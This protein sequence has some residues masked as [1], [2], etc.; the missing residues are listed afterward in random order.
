MTKAKTIMVVIQDFFFKLPHKCYKEVFK[1]RKLQL[2][3]CG[4]SWLLCANSCFI[5]NNR[6]WSEDLSVQLD[7]IQFKLW[8]LL[9]TKPSICTHIV[10]N[11]DHSGHDTSYIV[12]ANTEY[13]SIATTITKKWLENIDWYK[14]WFQFCL[15]HN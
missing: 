8:S 15:L 4:H 13:T 2:T 9:T 14:D 3:Y 1:I 12:P 6:L 10:W 11:F 5:S 7:R